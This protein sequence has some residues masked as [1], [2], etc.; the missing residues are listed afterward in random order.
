MKERIFADGLSKIINRLDVS[1]AFLSASAVLL[2]SLLIS[3]DVAEAREPTFFLR[4]SD[5]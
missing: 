1:R 5:I 4:Y 2:T 3:L